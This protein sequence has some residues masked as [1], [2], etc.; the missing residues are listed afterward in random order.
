MTAQEKHSQP[1][2][3]Y[4]GMVVMHLCNLCTAQI[5]RIM[6][7]KRGLMGRL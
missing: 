6:L 4:R 7:Q 3:V 2:N 1:T 5:V